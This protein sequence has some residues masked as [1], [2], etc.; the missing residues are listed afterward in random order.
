[1]RRFLVLFTTYKKELSWIY[2]FM[3]LSE[4][5]CLS[6]PFLL[7]KGIDGLIS[8][9]WYWTC[10]LALS[11]L[12]SVTF[13][14]KNMIYDTKI[15]TKIYNGIALSFLKNSKSNTSTKISRVDMANDIVHV[16][17][18][19]V[20]YY[21]STIVTIIGSA[22]FIYTENW[23]V[24]VLISVAG[25]LIVSAVFILYGKIK[26]VIN[27]RNNNDETKSKSIEIG[28]LSS[29][30]FFERRR[31]IAIYESTIQG[32][33]WL[34]ANSIKYAFL[35]AAIILLSTTTKDITIGSV[36]TVY[37]YVNNFLGA[38]LSAPVFAEMVLRMTDV[39]KRL[40]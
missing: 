19:H 26:Q 36:I 13:M 2:L 35:L 39:L 9:N 1:M 17:E 4:L 38:M 18:G 14:Y 10:L 34:I 12:V 24:G 16:L 23:K 7:G 20:H 15:Y 30:S 8:G 25:I 22:I 6:T 28:Y 29:K 37:S 11:Y 32:K 40:D 5:A 3:L 31:R 33:N 27:I 21:I